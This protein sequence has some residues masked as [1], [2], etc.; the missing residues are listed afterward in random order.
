MPLVRCRVCRNEVADDA[1]KCTKCGSPSFKEPTDNGIP[2]KRYFLWGAVVIVLVLA[3]I[4][5]VR[6]VIG[7][8][9][10]N[11]LPRGP[12]ASQNRR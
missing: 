2:G 12:G 11:E 10:K 8:F 9:P 5:V 4:Y 6:S 3:A 1:D 7:L